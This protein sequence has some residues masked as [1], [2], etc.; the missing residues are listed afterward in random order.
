MSPVPSNY[1]QTFQSS[2][3][4][5]SSKDDPNATPSAGTPSVSNL[6]PQA[7]GQI[8]THSADSRI[9]STDILSQP[10]DGGA[11][12][13]Q[14]A[15]FVGRHTPNDDKSQLMGSGDVICIDSDGDSD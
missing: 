7:T 8:S 4:T 11:S 15:N 14:Q 10:L 2:S 1:G 6:T 5:A 12:N 13:S 3:P 9:Y